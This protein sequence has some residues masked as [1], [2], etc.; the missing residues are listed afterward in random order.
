MLSL[1]TLVT[2]IAVS[3]KFF[4][5]HIGIVVFVVCDFEYELI[6][7]CAIVVLGTNGGSIWVS[8]S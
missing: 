7:L 3:Q 1:Q 8:A 2:V 6:D 4:G 5:S